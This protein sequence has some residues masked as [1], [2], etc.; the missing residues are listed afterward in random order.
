MIAA[1]KR[2]VKRLEPQTSIVLCNDT[3]SAADDC[4]A[5]HASSEPAPKLTWIVTVLRA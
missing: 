1:V 4:R 2:I 3:A 5:L